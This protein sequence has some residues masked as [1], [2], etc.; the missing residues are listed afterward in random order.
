M[1]RPTSVSR[2][3][4]VAVLCSGEGNLEEIRKSDPERCR[5]YI[6]QAKA[7]GAWLAER[8]VHLLTGGG[9][10]LMAAVSEGFHEGRKEERG[11]VIGVIPGPKLKS[12]YPNRWVEIPILTHLPGND[13]R[14]AE[15][16]N[17]I[18]V[19]TAQV[20]IALPGGGGT[21][22]EIELARHTYSKKVAVYLEDPS[23][24]IGGLN[25]TAL[26]ADGYE[27]FT[28][29]SALREFV[30]KELSRK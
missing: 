25:A 17:H 15:S 7:L 16:R 9:G 20:I 22:A 24:T 11:M 27:V 14:S 4:I 12:G 3:K 19:L 18:N 6:D 2:L 13:P 1:T 8:N 23:D 26:G 5:R 10:G 30:V 28:D 29:A 21:R